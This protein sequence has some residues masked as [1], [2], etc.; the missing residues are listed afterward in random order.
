MGTL[1]S[2]RYVRTGDVVTSKY[3]TYSF[4][5]GGRYVVEGI[6]NCKHGIT[7][8]IKGEYHLKSHFNLGEGI[9]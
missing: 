4:L 3:T 9:E 2:L 6:G 5:Q 8:K 1:T 7:L